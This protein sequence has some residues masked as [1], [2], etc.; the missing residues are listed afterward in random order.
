MPASTT[1]HKGSCFCGKVRF[2]IKGAIGPMSN[3]HCTDCRKSHAAA[4]ATYI[5]VPQG[6]LTFKKGEDHLQTYKAESGTKR[7]FCRTCGTIVTCWG[8]GDPKFLEISASTL[9]TP[10]N[11]K[12]EYHG[13]VRSKASWVD[14]QDGKPQ[15]MKNKGD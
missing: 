14:I 8:D 4:F 2:E 7:S 10:I 11:L 15:Y 6:A 3:C 12:P 13:Y 9:D 1:V 5:D